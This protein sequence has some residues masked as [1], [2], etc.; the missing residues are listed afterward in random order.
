MQIQTVIQ[1]IYTNIKIRMKASY[2]VLLNNNQSVIAYMF[3]PNIIM[4]NMVVWFLKF[5]KQDFQRLPPQWILL[6]PGTLLQSSMK[7][8]KKK[9]SEKC[10]LPSTATLGISQTWLLYSTLGNQKW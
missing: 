8:N 3:W 5:S 9:I 7:K 1:F 4:L 6:L 2:L 10:S